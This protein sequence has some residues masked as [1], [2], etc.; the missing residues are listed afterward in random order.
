MGEN[1]PKARPQPPTNLP[2]YLREGVEKQSPDRLRRLA[3][4]AEQMA[5]WKEAKAKRE[6]EE[7]ADQEIDVT[8][9]DW[10]DEEWEAQM[11]E[12][13]EK[14]DISGGKGT[15]VTKNIDGRQYYYLNWREGDTVKSQYVAPVTPSDGD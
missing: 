12:A 7:R 13:L 2:K 6:L 10:D 4:Y 8:P 9:E 14:A 11:D 1:E 15:L 5:D 3:E